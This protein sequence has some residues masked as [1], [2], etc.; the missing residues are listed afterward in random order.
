[1]NWLAWIGLGAV[2]FGSAILGSK[3]W[4]EKVQDWLGRR[5]GKKYR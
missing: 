2:L 4:L 1:M 3:E 5:P